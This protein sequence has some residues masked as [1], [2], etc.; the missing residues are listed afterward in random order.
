M[1]PAL[2][3]KDDCEVLQARTCSKEFR[4]LKE[5]LGSLAKDTVPNCSILPDDGGPETRDCLVIG[6]KVVLSFLI[7]PVKSGESHLTGLDTSHVVTAKFRPSLA[8]III[9]FV[10]SVSDKLFEKTSKI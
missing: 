3:C 5:R 6:I 2:L 1:R 4:L 9:S 10:Q 7:F 8:F